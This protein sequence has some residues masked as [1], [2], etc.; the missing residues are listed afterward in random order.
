[1]RLNEKTIVL[2]HSGTATLF[3]FGDMQYGAEGF[4]EGMWAD[5]ERDFKSTPNAYA[6]GL[7]DYSDFSR[8]TTRH[9]MSDALS[10]DRSVW[11]QLDKM[12]HTAVDGLSDKLSFM[13]GRLIGLHSGHHEWEFES[14]MTTTKILCHKLGA[15]WLDW[16]SY[17]VLKV[18]TPNPKSGSSAI[19]IWS[20][21]GSGG[22]SFSSG[23]LGNLEKKIAPYWVAD[24]YLRGHSSKLEMIPMELNDV[25]VRH[26]LRLVK[27][28]RWLV[29]CGGFM[30]GYPMD[31]SSYVERNALPPACLG[32]AKCEIKYANYTN[33]LDGGKLAGVRIQPTLCSPNVILEEGEV[34]KNVHAK[35]AGASAKRSRRNNS[36]G[37]SRRTA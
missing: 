3:V 27:R 5:F 7:G 28:T 9:K 37:S 15:P 12:V 21:H 4:D 16:T 11:S 33:D 19:K 13:K 14:G 17:T 32:Y 22:S 34:W 35:P 18:R 29:N 24:L 10:G 6:I 25:T 1:M 20:T 31:S 2:P 30:S 8:W 26:G 36:A 23:D